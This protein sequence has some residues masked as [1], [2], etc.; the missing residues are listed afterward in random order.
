MRK[1]I[2]VSL[3]LTGVAVTLVATILTVFSFYR[4]FSDRVKTELK[5]DAL[6]LSNHLEHSTDTPE[7]YLAAIDESL[8]EELRTTLIDPDG[9]VTYDTSNNPKHM[10]NHADRPEFIEALAT[11]EGESVRKSETLGRDA[12]YYALKLESGGVL[13]VSRRIDSITTIFLNILPIVL[14]ILLLLLVESV[15][16][17]SILTKKLI[18]PFDRAIQTLGRTDADEKPYYEE[19]E[20]FFNR[21]REQNEMIN[22][23][24]ERIRR[25]RQTLDT[26]TSQMREGLIILDRKRMI[27]SVNSSAVN[28]LAAKGQ[29]HVGKSLLSLSRNLEIN[30][31]A[32]GA[33]YRG[34]SQDLTLRLG[35]EYCRIFVNP[36]RSDDSV[37]GAIILIVTVTD[38]VKAERIRRDFSANVS[39]ELKT[40]L[41]SIT[42][43][44]EM[45]ENGMASDPDDIKRFSAYIHREAV[46]LFALINDIMRLSEIEETSGHE[47][48]EPV[49]LQKLSDEVINSLSFMA[50]DHKVTLELAGSPVALQTNL[51]MLEELL[52]NLISNAIRYNKQGGRVLVTTGTDGSMAV[53][54]VKDTGIGIPKEHQ[55]RVFERFYRVDKSRSHESGGTGLGLSI[56]KHVVEYLDGKIKLES[57]ENLGTEIVVS[58]PMS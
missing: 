7:S 17:S 19:L 57:S 30:R 32:E 39:H 18:R 43:F 28:L 14:V 48:F 25:E 52:Y 2:Y 21:I 13:R 29:R 40:P 46:R 4:F 31:A 23:Y 41:T 9:R 49:E 37:N 50:D 38:Q 34:E 44:A 8:K 5:T 51:R 27:L 33:L 26:I 42:G 53:I 15:A 11:G 3:C 58:L 10:E 20:P 35:N 6:L 47:G 16:I 54:A 36:A 24:I 22:E 12:Y 55:D 56:V 45:I 1:K